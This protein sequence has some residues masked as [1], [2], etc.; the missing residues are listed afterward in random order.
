MGVSS[1]GKA[2][3]V[4]DRGARVRRFREKQEQ[5]DAFAQAAEFVVAPVLLGFLG[6][7]LDNRLGTAPLF[8]VAF[9]IIGFVGAGLANYYRY[10]AKV[11]HDDEGKP[12]TRRQR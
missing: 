12:W 2:F 9:G 6:W 1:G 10:M 11:E 4:V 7:L 3:R 8:M 5:S